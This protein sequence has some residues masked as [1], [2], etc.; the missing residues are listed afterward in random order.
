MMSCNVV[1]NA[2]MLVIGG[3]YSNA[4]IDVCDV[5]T[6]QGTHNMN[7]G[8]QNQDKAIW[9]QYQPNL[10]TYIVPTDILTAVGGHNTGGATKTT[11]VS[12]FDAPDLAVQMERTAKSGTR[13]ATRQVGSTT[14]KPPSSSSHTST[15]SPSL[16]AGAI[17]GIAVGGSVALI[18]AL[19]G[20][21]LVFNRRRKYYT[22]SH[23]VTAPPV[24]D[25]TMINS[26]SPGPMQG[27]WDFNQVPPVTETAASYPD[28]QFIRPTEY[29]VEL[30]SD[31][32]LPDGEWRMS[33]TSTKFQ[34]GGSEDLH[35]PAELASERQL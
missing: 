20:C 21:F 35:L 5:P 31:R 22:H 29:A 2:Q 17:A 10:T 28:Q 27:G 1:D 8:E 24:G 19:A 26:A 25:M 16:S 14:T 32:G 30:T 9:A 18:L 4:S 11:P 6:I 34:S 33:P 12:G 23:G 15:P 7:L 13:T 3:T